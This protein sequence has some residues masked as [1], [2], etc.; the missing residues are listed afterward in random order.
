[1]STAAFLA[2]AFFVGASAARHLL[3]GND[4]PAIRKMLSMALWM[5]LI[6]SPIQAMLGDAH[7]LNTLEH[8]PAKIAAIEGHWENPPDEPT[9]LILFGLPDMEQE[10]PNMRWKFRISAA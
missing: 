10:K 1:M 6:V 5:A 3:R 7:G 2:S 8:Q 9:P 4:T